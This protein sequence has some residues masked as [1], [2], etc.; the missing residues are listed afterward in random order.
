MTRRI[1]LSTGDDRGQLKML[2]EG[3]AEDSNEQLD[4]DSQV[5]PEL[6]AHTLRITD[7]LE[8]TKVMQKAGVDSRV[9]DLEGSG[10]MPTKGTT[11]GGTVKFGTG[12]E[13]FAMIFAK[14]NAPINTY[15]SISGANQT[16]FTST[17]EVMLLA[18]NLEQHNVE[19]EDWNNRNIVITVLAPV[20]RPS[21]ETHANIIAAV[22]KTS[23]SSYDESRD[24]AFDLTKNEKVL[25]EKLI[26]D[27]SLLRPVLAE[28][29]NGTG[30]ANNLTYFKC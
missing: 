20:P 12:I 7:V 22:G 28:I 4:Q 29:T 2:K 18:E 21:K 15:T 27:L 5:Q 16:I 24:I 8:G 25:R 13:R 3:G 11:Y 6:K 30:I 19:E 26:T 10:W 23:D 9:V 1:K 17:G 14:V